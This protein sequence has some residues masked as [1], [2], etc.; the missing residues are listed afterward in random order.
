VTGRRPSARSASVPSAPE[1]T[2]TRLIISALIPKS[3]RMSTGRPAAI[4]SR[5]AVEDTVTSP[6]APSSASVIDPA[7]KRRASGSTRPAWT[8]RA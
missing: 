8:S 7:A 1:P 3:L 2:N 4:A 6:R 5:A